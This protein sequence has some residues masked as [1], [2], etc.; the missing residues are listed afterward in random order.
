MLVVRE[1]CLRVSGK[2]NTGPS[3]S[4]PKLACLVFSAGSLSCDTTLLRETGERRNNIP[5]SKAGPCNLLL[6]NLQ[7][8]ADSRQNL[9][10]TVED[11]MCQLHLSRFEVRLYIPG[12]QGFK[13]HLFDC[14]FVPKH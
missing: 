5:F 11:K 12:G 3:P 6:E 14:T 2:Q 8:E 4:P 1:Q 7:V 9:T 10:E 13:A